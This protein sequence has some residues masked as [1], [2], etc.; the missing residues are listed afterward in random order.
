MNLND[1]IQEIIEQDI[2]GLPWFLPVNKLEA[3]L[4]N[5]GAGETALAQLPPLC[6]AEKFRESVRELMRSGRVTKEMLAQESLKVKQSPG[7]PGAFGL[8][9]VEPRFERAFFVFGLRRG[10]NH[11]IAEWLKGHFDE[12]ETLYLNSA[13][14][15]F[16]E[17]NGGG[18]RIDNADY[19]NISPGGGEKILLVGYENLDFMDFP[20]QHNARIA[21]RSEM[22]IVLRDY[23]NMAASIAR[24]A[25]ERPDFVFKYRL[26]D[27]PQNWAMY[28]HHLNRRTGGF[29]YVKF[30]D[31]FSSAEYRKELSGR[32]GME[33]SDR[34]L[35]TVSSYGSG[36]S[37]DKMTQDNNAQSMNVLHRW[38]EMMNDDLFCF[39]LLAG[40]D[41]LALNDEIFGNFPID[42]EELMSRWSEK[43]GAETKI[44]EAAGISK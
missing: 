17:T 41:N 39:L 35:N 15:G 5:L 44:S 6:V 32:L 19:R 12:G 11:A 2:A 38:E 33:F 4:R 9:E 37:F 16:F 22:V 21:G 28:A 42:K 29:T 20:F 7:P 18:L 10:G 43:K 23:P 34:G 25:R 40:G 30:N 8:P 31:W 26:R 13:E 24:S 36:S 14:I 1:D 3:L 27:L